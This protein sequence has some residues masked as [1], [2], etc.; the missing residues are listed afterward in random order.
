MEP[1]EMQG[2]SS[3]ILKH[4]RL[5]HTEPPYLRVT[6]AWAWL[7]HEKMNYGATAC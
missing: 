4:R 2:V 6:A 5:L 1:A 7:H 3:G